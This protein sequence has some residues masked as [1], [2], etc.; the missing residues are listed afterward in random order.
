MRETT[1]RNLTIV[2]PAYNE[3]GH[4]AKTL[5][6]VLEAATG[7]LDNFE[8]I[9]VDDG[10]RDATGRIADE[11]A[12]RDSRIRVVHQAKNQGVGAAFIIGLA[13]ARFESITVV[14]GDNAFSEDTLKEV[15][16]AVGTAPLIVSYRANMEVRTPVR[17]LLSIA[18]TWSMRIITGRWIRDA[19]S[20]FVY[21]VA[22]ARQVQVQPGYGYH[23]E[24]LGR[25]LLAAPSYREIPAILNPRPDANSGVMRLSV[26]TLLV[27]TM[28]RLAWWRAGMLLLPGQG[29]EKS[30]RR[31]TSGHLLLI[32]CAVLA[33]MAAFISGKALGLDKSEP[34]GRTRFHAIPV[35]ISQIYHGWQ[36]DYTADRPIAMQFQSTLPLPGLIR[37]AVL[38]KVRPND[39]T[40]FWTAD[41]RGLSDFVNMAFRM[42]GPR[43]A[44]LYYFW[45]AMLAASLAVALI[46]FRR[47]APAL[48]GIAAVTIAVVAILPAY[49]RDPSGNATIHI[50]ES[51]AFEV[52]GA[53][54]VLHVVLALL[55]LRT[56]GPWAW[57][58]AL[59]SQI[60]LLTFLM[61]TRSSLAW[62]FVV[63]IAIA[64]A[65]AAFRCWSGS[66][67]RAALT[68]SA[69]PVT[70]LI[71]GWVTM[72]GYQGLM[73][74]PAYKGEIGPRTFW[75]NILMGL[76]Y[77]PTFAAE[78][79][80]TKVSDLQAVE[81]VLADARERHDTRIS[82]TGTAQEVLNSLGSHNTFDW[83]SYEQV[84]RDLVVRTIIAR[85]A[86]ALQLVL[87]DKPKAIVE[88]IVC[89]T[90]LVKTLCGVQEVDR[91]D[92]R[93][94]PLSWLPIGLLLILM[95][96]YYLAMQSNWPE[97]TLN[98]PLRP[99][100]AA[101]GCIA[102][103]GL[104]P[105][106]V[107]YPAFTQ[108]AGTMIFGMAVLYLAITML[109]MR[110]IQYP[111]TFRAKTPSMQA[112]DD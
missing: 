1:M 63:L 31:T 60:T 106:L 64:M 89:D 91:S 73:F 24:S 112:A 3:E 44:A 50:S 57:F 92:I 33:V 42:F 56:V 72:A 18:C 74:N 94:N 99:I 107:F 5:A 98:A 109:L 9:V 6:A 110:L 100:L 62:L 108:L 53:V 101:A 66:Q 58:A 84:A 78:L 35:A 40:Y 79:K 96:G 59:T 67:W 95:G 47:D 86:A 52:L 97:N 27:L 28:L 61:H 46:T 45:F 103:V 111:A 37:D 41:D 8:I 2:V 16:D 55:R 21:P 43:V 51:R 29:A 7:M 71:V 11:A 19:H 38:A 54:A 82:H 10:S 90:M 36:H 105:S 69:V 4:I 14:P 83:R 13:E 88:T 93:V 104:L 26:V 76:K 25:L 102:L 39:Q 32:G 22:L 85:P 17:R 49:V 12:Q 30:S 34:S 65:L 75:H 68:R 20:M 15:F 80:I 70:L 77:N 23:I 48:A 81:A 87:S